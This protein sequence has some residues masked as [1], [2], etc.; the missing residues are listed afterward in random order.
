[1]TVLYRD[2]YPV[3]RGNFAMAGDASSKIKRLLKRMD[4]DPVLI[5]KLR[6]VHMNLSLIL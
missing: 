3:E 1:M 2:I 6:Y 4:V 5:R